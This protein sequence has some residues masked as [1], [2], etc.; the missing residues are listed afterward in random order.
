MKGL[1][2]GSNAK[3][4]S[5]ALTC[6]AWLYRAASYG[7]PNKTL[8][9]TCDIVTDGFERRDQK[10]TPNLYRELIPIK[11]IAELSYGLHWDWTPIYV[12]KQIPAA[13]SSRSNWFHTYNI[14]DRSFVK[15]FHSWKTG[16]SVVKFSLQF[17]SAW[18]WQ[19]NT[20]SSIVNPGNLCS[21]S[22]LASKHNFCLRRDGRQIAQHSRYKWG[23]AFS[24]T[25]DNG[26]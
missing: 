3:S 19:Y 9:L 16:V 2:T 10:L 8:S 18:Q 13:N 25:S 24:R 6:M 17:K 20:Y 11:A 26:D 12:W 23:F 7:A 4:R 21:I 22:H 1:H 5:N 14:F 15:L